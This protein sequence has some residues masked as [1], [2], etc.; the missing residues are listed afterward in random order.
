[1]VRIKAFLCLL[2]ALCSLVITLQPVAAAYC[3][4][5]VHCTNQCGDLP[6]V[7]EMRSPFYYEG[8]LGG[9]CTETLSESGI[10]VRVEGKGA[11][12]VLI[13]TTGKPF[14]FRS[15]WVG[16]KGRTPDSWYFEQYHA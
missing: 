10:R 13:L 8:K 16:R 9:T 15:E 14:P 12:S 6:A 2:I 4:D 7:M 5:G 1:M 11:A 3:P